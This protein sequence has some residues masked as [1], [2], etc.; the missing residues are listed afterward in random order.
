MSNHK[1]MCFTYKLVQE[2]VG[3]F[4]EISL[5]GKLIKTMGIVDDWYDWTAP[6]QV[7]DFIYRGFISRGVMLANKE[8][9]I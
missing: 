8:R 2:S 3:E 7:R 9:E 4:A 1:Y 6:D 5:Q